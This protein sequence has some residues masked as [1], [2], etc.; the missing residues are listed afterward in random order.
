MKPTHR[1]L[2]AASVVLSSL[3]APVAVPLGVEAWRRDARAAGMPTITLTGLMDQGAWTDEEVTAGNAWRRDF[4]RARP[5]LRVGGTVRLRL[6]SADVVHSFAAPGLGIDPVEVYPGRVLE[7]TVTPAAS[8][9]FEYY[10][11]TVCGRPHFAMRG[12][13]EVFPA[14]G[15]TLPPLPERPGAGYWSI[16]PPAGNGTVARGAWLYRRQ[17]CVTCHGEAGAGGVP[18]PNSMNALVPNLASLARRT[19]FFTAADLGAFLTVLERS[20]PLATV[21][22]APA[23]PLFSLVKAQYLATYHLVRDGRRSSKLD[24]A[25][26]HPP[27]DMPAWGARLSDDELNAILAYLLTLDGGAGDGASPPHRKGESP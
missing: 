21:K 16:P 15:D 27:L 10:C 5:Q 8:G 9:I 4:R 26:H 24:P 13:L 14:E 17:G 12:F 18:N 23:V 1:E 7:L 25:G 20:T 22:E 19:F 3:V 11:T 2:L 6:A